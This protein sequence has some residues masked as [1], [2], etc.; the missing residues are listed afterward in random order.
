MNPKLVAKDAIA[1]AQRTQLSDD[2][3][4]EISRHLNILD[5]Q[6]Y[7]IKMKL[8]SGQI[9]SQ[10]RKRINESDIAKKAKEYIK[11]NL[12]ELIQKKEKKGK[13]CASEKLILQELNKGRTLLELIP[14]ITAHNIFDE[15]TYSEM[16]YEILLD[17]YDK[18]RTLQELLPFMRAQNFPNQHILSNLWEMLTMIEY[19]SGRRLQ[20][21]ISLAQNISPSQRSWVWEEILMNQYEKGRTLQE[22]LPFITAQNFPNQNVRSDIMKKLKQRRA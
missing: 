4:R 11:K 13:R 15:D 1:R 12:E 21:L 2:I 9:K 22:L 17:Q 19:E 14:L 18:V 7:L 10:I 8:P 3:H 5:A 6:E 20:E 16:W